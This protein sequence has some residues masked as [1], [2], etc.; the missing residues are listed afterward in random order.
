M[1]SDEIRKIPGETVGTDKK[2]LEYQIDFNLSF[3]TLVRYYYL[4]NQDPPTE[5]TLF[6]A[7]NE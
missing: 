1:Y 4:I 7:R 3:L 5:I 6:K 2:Y